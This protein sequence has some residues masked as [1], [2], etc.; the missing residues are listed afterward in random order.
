MDCFKRFLQISLCEYNAEFDQKVYQ[1]PIKYS[2]YLH[3]CKKE[4]ELV[5]DLICKNYFWPV[6]SGH[7]LNILW[8]KKT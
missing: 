3:L 1:L 4:T 5:E 8:I 6:T 7:T 2:N